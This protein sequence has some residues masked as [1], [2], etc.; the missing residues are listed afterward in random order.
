MC[1]VRCQEFTIDGE[2]SDGEYKEQL[3]FVQGEGMRAA[4]VYVYAVEGAQQQQ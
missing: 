3:I 2:G 4:V 1:D